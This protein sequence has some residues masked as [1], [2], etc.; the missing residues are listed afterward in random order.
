MGENEKAN[1]AKSWLIRCQAA[2]GR[3]GPITEGGCHFVDCHCETL[4]I[5]SRFPSF[6]R[7]CSS[8]GTYSWLAATLSSLVHCFTAEYLTSAY[9]TRPSMM[10]WII[11]SRDQPRSHRQMALQY[12]I[13]LGNPRA[14]ILL[15]RL[16]DYTDLII[17]PSSYKYVRQTSLVFDIAYL[18]KGS[19]RAVG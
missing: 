11:V 16:M 14:S 5:L 3:F 4:P 10:T 15:L 19:S 2:S 17:P 12:N 1:N 18:A 7:Q 6:L 8:C 13:K 9:L